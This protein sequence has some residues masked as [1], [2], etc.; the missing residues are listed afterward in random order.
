[1]VTIDPKFIEY[2]ELGTFLLDIHNPDG[3]ICISTPGT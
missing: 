3:L 2:I 1:M